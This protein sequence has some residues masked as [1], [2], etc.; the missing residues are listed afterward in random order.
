MGVGVRRVFNCSQQRLL[1][2]ETLSLTQKT[3]KQAF[4][5]LILVAAKLR[6]G[7]ESFSLIVR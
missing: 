7:E 3:P 2:K 4:F 1:R 5:L 6:Q